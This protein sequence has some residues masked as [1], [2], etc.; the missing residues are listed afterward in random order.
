MLFAFFSVSTTH[1]RFH[2]DRNM[3]R[4]RR[5]RG[6]G[7][8]GGATRIEL[9]SDLLEGGITPSAGLIE[10]VRAELRGPANHDSPARRRF[11]L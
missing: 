9:C 3:C 5:L 11:L 8:R 6:C 7:E 10:L 1:A 2:L 4:L